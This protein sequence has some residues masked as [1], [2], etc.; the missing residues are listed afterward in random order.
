[1]SILVT[2]PPEKLALLD[3]LAQENDL[4]GIVAKAIIDTLAT[5]TGAALTTNSPV[6]PDTAAA[7]VGNG[8]L[9]ARDNH[10]HHIA[11]ATGLV[12][13]LLAAADKTKLDGVAT[14]ATALALATAAPAD[15]DTAAAAVGSGTKAAKDDHK[16][17]IAVAGVAEGLMPADPV[18]SPAG[19]YTIGTGSGQLV[20]VQIDAHGRVIAVTLGS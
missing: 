17:H 6:D 13:G 9:A 12:A 18:A 16:H 15:P 4:L 2:I 11:V 14:G 19:T 5:A 3:H 10:K 8:T 20:G 7:A 1:M